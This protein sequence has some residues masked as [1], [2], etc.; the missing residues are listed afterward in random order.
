MKAELDVP[1][2]VKDAPVSSS[3]R[4]LGVTFVLVCVIACAGWMWGFISFDANLIS[5]IVASFV[6]LVIA[7][8]AV[9]F[10]AK[11]KS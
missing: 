1:E 4:F 2:T 11:N 3:I 5:K 6:L 7:V 9:F 8:W 10:L